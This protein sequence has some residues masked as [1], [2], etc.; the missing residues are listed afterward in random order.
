MA[1]RESDYRLTLRPVAKWGTPATIRL[2]L[3]LKSAL[4]CFGLRC[5]KIEAL[6]ADRRPTAG[7]EPD[8][9][10]GRG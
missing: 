7:A 5:L 1:D 10:E 4:R 3:L 2:R 8:T 9:G 6:P